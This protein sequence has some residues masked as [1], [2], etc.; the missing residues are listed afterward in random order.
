MCLWLQLYQGIDTCLGVYTHLFECVY[1]HIVY[2]HTVWRER[3][4]LSVC[5][6]VYGCKC[7]KE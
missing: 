1:T 5:K 3:V 6:C 4:C 7:I 2:T